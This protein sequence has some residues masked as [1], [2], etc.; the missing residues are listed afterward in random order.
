[1]PTVLRTAQRVVIEL[2]ILGY[3]CLQRDV[4]SHIKTVLIQKQC[5]KKPAHPAVAVIERMNAK[6]VMDKYGNGYQRLNLRIAR[7]PCIFF[8]YPVQ[9]LGR[10]KRS[11]RREQ[12]LRVSVRVRGAYIILHV[13]G[14]ARHRI[15]HMR[16]KHFVQLQY[17][18][19]RER[20]GI[21]TFMYDVERVAIAGDLLLV[22]VPR[23]CL[24]FNQLPDARICGHDALYRIGRFGAL[25]FGYLD[26]FIQF[27]GR[28]LQAHFLLARLFADRR[29]KT[30]DLGIPLDIFETGIVKSPHF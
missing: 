19:A 27:L 6:K 2:L 14:L 24:F 12:C 10:F 28:L 9:R 30:E 5:R 13:L 8:A 1:M 15:A 7:H 29:N 11:K 23:R 3:L 18:V 26:Q 20:N 16:V 25:H 22:A 21:E 4:S 17:I